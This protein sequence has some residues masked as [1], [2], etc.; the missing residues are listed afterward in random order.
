LQRKTRLKTL[1]LPAEA[2]PATEAAGQPAK[3]EQAD[4]PEQPAT[5][6]RPQKFD[7]AVLNQ[8]KKPGACYKP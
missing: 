5:E 7:S 1:Q 8:P 4:Q 3:V 2:A 6:T